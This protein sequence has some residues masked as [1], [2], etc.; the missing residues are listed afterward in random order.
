M[1]TDAAIQAIFDFEGVISAAVATVFR[2]NGFDAGNALTILSD[3]AFQKKRPRLEIFFS[4]HGQVVPQRMAVQP[5]GTEIPAAYKGTLEIHAI[6]APNAAGKQVHSLYR[7]KVRYFCGKL[8]SQVNGTALTK[9]KIQSIVATDTQINLKT[10][11]GYEGSI[12]TFDVA[13]SVQSDAWGTL[14]SS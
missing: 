7:S 14:A 13:F 8:R 6:T 4:E 9:H 10:A 5:D 12:F 3:P 11:D 1:P 2:S